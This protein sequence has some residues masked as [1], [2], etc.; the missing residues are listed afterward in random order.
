MPAVA[1]I[2]AEM[3]LRAH[4]DD[5]RRFCGVLQQD[6]RKKRSHCFFWYRLR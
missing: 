3:Q 6:L 5:E 2:A 4:A 1:K